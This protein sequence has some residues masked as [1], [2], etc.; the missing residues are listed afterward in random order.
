MAYDE[1][2]AA[3]VRHHFRL[4]NLA[5]EEK[6]MMGGLCFMVND[7][8]CAGVTDDRLMLRI[9]PADMATALAR[10]GCVPMDFTG[11][12]LKSFVFVEATAWR[13]AKEFTSWMDQAI[14]FNPKAKAAKK[15]TKTAAKKTVAR[16]S[17]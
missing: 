8:M 16:R 5:W 1:K 6:T 12:P 13:R 11:R 10:P 4:K 2:L 3:Q 14:A 17:R 7:K 9:D 15:R